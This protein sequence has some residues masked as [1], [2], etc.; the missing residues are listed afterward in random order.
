MRD[1]DAPKE[2]DRAIWAEAW[3]IGGLMVICLAGALF[4]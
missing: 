2:P 4:G 3:F 1:W